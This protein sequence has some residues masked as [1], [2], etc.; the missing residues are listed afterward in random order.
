MSQLMGNSI[1]ICAMV[2][3]LV[4]QVIKFLI[5]WKI[6]HRIRLSRLFG[7]GGMPSAHTAF[8]V[9][10]AM[11]IAFR[12]GLGSTSFAIAF[13]LAAVVINDAVGVRYQT[14]EQSKLINQILH[15]MLVEGKP[16]SDENLK[17]L[18]GHTPTEAFFG[19]IIGLI[20]PVFFI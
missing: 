15:Q 14:G 7:N 10:L 4:A 16:L 3:W 9:S 18:M 13:A 6:N 1:L 8:V 5:D 17:E 19:A 2:S 11:M 20:I 12:E